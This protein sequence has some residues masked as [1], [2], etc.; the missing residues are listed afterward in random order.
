MTS[1]RD[2]KI[3]IDTCPSGYV[4]MPTDLNQG[5]GGSDLFLCIKNNGSS[6][7]GGNYG[8]TDL[9]IADGGPCPSGYDRDPTD[10]N[11]GAGGADLFLC[12]RSGYGPL[13]SNV[14]LTTSTGATAPSGYVK[15]PTDLNRGAGGADIFLWQKKQSMRDYC[16][17]RLYLAQ[18]KEWCI[19][20]PA[21]CDSSAQQFCAA[22]PSDPFCACLTSNYANPKLGINPKCVDPKCLKPGV[23]LT[24]NM[25]RTACPDVVTCEVQNQIIS[26][27]L[28]LHTNI[29]IQ[30]NCG[31][32]TN[33]KVDTES[34]G[35]SASTITFVLIFIFIILTV[36]SVFIMRRI[37]RG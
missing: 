6:T 31:S 12:K 29:P 22:H 4:R 36:M 20:N 37:M 28:S 24:H 10:L 13:V 35:G 30:Q 9:A 18:C 27:G 14:Y 7:T 5:A 34:T 19:A 32:Q 26:S 16:S 11:R 17:P 3:G 33:T 2:V 25:A 8:I 15:L 21:E 1:I 23:Y